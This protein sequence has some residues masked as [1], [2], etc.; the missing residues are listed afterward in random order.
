V[1]LRSLSL[2]IPK[3]QFAT[4]IGS[5]GAGKT[6]LVSVV[7]GSVVPVA[8]LIE[9]HGHN[10]SNTREHER[11]R[12][13]ARVFQDP[14]V[15]TCANFSIEENLAM[16][17]RRGLRRGFSPA[18]T[19]KSRSRYADFLSQFGL[20]FESR[21][22]EKVGALSGGQRQALALLMAVMR[23]PDILL[24]DEHTAALD[25]KNRAMLQE[26]TER[27]VREQG[28]TTIMVTHNMEA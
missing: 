23:A 11:S 6:T 17:E 8:G 16:A 21:L 7:A 4:I 13:V 2:G 19:R 10:I 25:P 14:Q 5:N 24:L 9:L 18:V 28:C 26:L 12:Y 27:V 3:G 15:G 20:G 22:S 1:A